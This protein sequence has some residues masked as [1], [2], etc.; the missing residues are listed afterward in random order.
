MPYLSNILSN[1]INLSLQSGIVPDHLK[2]ARVIPLFKSGDKDE[3]TN[4]R[5]V[6]ILPCISKIY[7]KVVYHR[8][9]SYLNK[10]DILNSNQYGFRNNHSTSMA[11]VDFVEKN[12]RI[13]EEKSNR[14]I[15]GLSMGGFHT[16]HI[17]RFYA[18]TFE[19]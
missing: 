10:N 4:Y 1:L 2:V 15:A 19:R 13:K 14:A 12:Y 11:I 5:P 9:I 7:E 18:N 8:L 16:I 6:S 3:I 17:S